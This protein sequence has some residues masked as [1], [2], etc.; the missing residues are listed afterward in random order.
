MSDI[1]SNI[2]LRCWLWGPRYRL[3]N[4]NMMIRS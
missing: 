1:L 2:A 3:L 4:N